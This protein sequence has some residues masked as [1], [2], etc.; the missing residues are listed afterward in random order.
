MAHTRLVSKE[1]GELYL[2]L[3]ARSNLAGKKD[4]IPVV[5]LSGLLFT[6]NKKD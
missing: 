4:A 1:K 6:V 5:E 2:Y 3:P